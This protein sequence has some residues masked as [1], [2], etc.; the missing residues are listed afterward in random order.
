M[1]WQSN[2]NHKTMWFVDGLCSCAYKYSKYEIQPKQFFPELKSLAN[3][4]EKVTGLEGSNCVNVNL[5]VNQHNKVGFHSDSEPIFQADYIPSS[6][7]SVSLG[8]ARQFT[9]RCK[10]DFSQS[11]DV[12]L[13]QGD[14][15]TMEGLCQ[16]FYQ[17]SLLASPAPCAPRINLT[18]RKIV[19]HR[20]NCALAEE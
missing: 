10:A 19:Q 3:F 12:L 2:D 20:N 6:I 7:I 5:Y 15:V 17:H 1:P 14:I 18:F 11:Y 16:K 8:A 9:I 4:V 13:E